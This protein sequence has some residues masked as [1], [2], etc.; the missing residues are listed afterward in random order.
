MTEEGQT[1]NLDEYGK[2]HTSCYGPSYRHIF[3]SYIDVLHNDTRSGNSDKTFSYSHSCYCGY[4]SRLSN[5][6]QKKLFLQHRHWFNLNKRFIYSL[7]RVGA[8]A[9]FS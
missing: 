2:K 1:R 7:C 9:H 5:T 4:L 3:G 8:P 6:E